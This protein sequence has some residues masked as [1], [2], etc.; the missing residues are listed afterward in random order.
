MYYYDVLLSSSA[1]QVVVALSFTAVLL[2]M[3]QG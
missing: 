3:E 2:A 1:V